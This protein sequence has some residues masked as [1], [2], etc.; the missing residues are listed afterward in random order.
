MQHDSFNAPAAEPRVQHVT[1]FMG[2]HHAE[3]RGAGENH[4][5][6]QVGPADS[7]GRIVT[8]GPDSTE[9]ELAF[10]PRDTLNTEVPML[11]HALIAAFLIAQPQ[12]DRPFYPPGRPAEQPR[13][14]N[15][16]G[17]WNHEIHFATSNDGL[18]FTESPAI[19]TQASVPDIIQLAR[20]LPKKETAA[21]AKGTL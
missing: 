12:P 16:D 18:T 14:Q 1:A 10:I 4:N 5:E 6:K 19:M 17:P 7:H 13:P 9:Y 3:P 11:I 21:G 2:D 8:S 20:D 15:Q